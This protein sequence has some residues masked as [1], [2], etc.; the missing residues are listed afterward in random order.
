[1]RLA[2]ALAAPVLAA[3][4]P[5][6]MAPAAFVLMAAGG[7]PPVTIF[8][9]SPNRAAQVYGPADMLCDLN[10][11][12]LF[13]LPSDGGLASGTIVE[14]GIPETTGQDRVEM[15]RCTEQL[16]RASVLG[17]PSERTS[18]PGHSNP[19]VFITP[20]ELRLE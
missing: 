20:V 7:R 6:A 15:R 17:Y 16:C 12:R 2:P 3:I 19:T 10:K 18:L 8:V 11:C 1:M 14:F 5:V 9:G 4:L 13:N